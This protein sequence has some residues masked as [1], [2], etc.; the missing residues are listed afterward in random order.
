M[1]AEKVPVKESA[2]ILIVEDKAD[3]V[4][5]ITRACEGAGFTVRSASTLAKAVSL[6]NTDLF[7][8]LVADIRL[9][10]W[11][12]GNIEGLETLR[13]VPEERRPVAVVLSAFADYDN[14]RLAFTDFDVVDVLRKSSFDSNEL[15]IKIK[16]AIRRTRRKR[17][18]AG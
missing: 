13:S 15:V 5:I 2:H 17:H 8:A 10:D 14:T 1:K 16:L 4:R 3:W 6:L 7:D 12:E 18:L 9:K 11:Q